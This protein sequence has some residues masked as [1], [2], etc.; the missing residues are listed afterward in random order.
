MKPSISK[1]AR[2]LLRRFEV[3]RSD[4]IAADQDFTVLGNPY[5]YACKRSSGGSVADMEGMA[6]ADDRRSFSKTI[7]VLLSTDLSVFGISP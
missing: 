6:E 4:I 5:V 2:R 7:L 1:S 3:A